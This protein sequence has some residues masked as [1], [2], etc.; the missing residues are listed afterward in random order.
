MLFCK[1]DANLTKDSQK[2]R[3]VSLMSA[4]E[5]EKKCPEPRTLPPFLT[6]NFLPSHCACVGAQ[7]AGFWGDFQKIH[8]VIGPC[9]NY[10]T[11]QLLRHQIWEYSLHLCACLQQFS[12]TFHLTGMSSRTFSKK[13]YLVA[14]RRALRR[15]SHSPLCRKKPTTLTHFA[16]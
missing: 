12:N 16:V 2:F 13:E 7:S 11:P 6:P 1:S 10:V 5:M 8:H 15:I 9:T 4:P 3:F 14:S